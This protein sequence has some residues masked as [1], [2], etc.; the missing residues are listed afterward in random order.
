MHHYDSKVDLDLH[1]KRHDLCEV[2]LELDRDHKLYIQFDN[3]VWVV[4]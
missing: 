4:L 1:T 2:D 3:T